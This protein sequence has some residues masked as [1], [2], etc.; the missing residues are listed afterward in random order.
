M[1]PNMKVNIAGVEFENPI[2]MASGTFSLDMEKY[3]NLDDLGAVT[4]KGVFAEP[5][6]G[7]PP[8]R[9]AET[10]SGMINS[11]GLQGEG[12]GGVIDNVLP[13]LKKYKTKVIANVCGNTVGEYAEVAE[14]FGAHVDM[15]E[16][17]VSCPNVKSGGIAFG[18]DSCKLE[19]VTKEV[20]KVAKLPIIV[21]LSPNVTSIADMAKAAE[22]GGA[23]CVSLINTLLSMKIDVKTRKPINAIN[24]G[25]LSGAAVKPVAVRM[26]WQVAK[27]V[28][29]PVIGMGG[30]MTGEDVVEFMLA[31]ASAVMVGT[32]NLIAPTASVR[33][34]DELEKYLIDNGINDINELVGGVIEHT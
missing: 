13:R 1:K 23:D 4:L 8:P 29:I 31:G 30:I 14:K 17:N 28:K 2:M 24:I 3:F 18:L 16:I 7:N 11:I 15:L 32:A 6:L 12:V 33:I 25:G 19:E 27:A 34:R 9:I 10:A 5:R 20:K 26:V 22:S 21:K